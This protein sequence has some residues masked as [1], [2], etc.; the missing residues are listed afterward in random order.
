MS[1]QPAMPETRPAV[2][3]YLRSVLGGESVTRAYYDE[4]ERHA[5]AVVEAA[6][7]PSTM[8]ITFATASLHASPNNM[9]G[10]DIRVELLIVAPKDSIAAANV[11]ATAG[12]FVMKDR[13]LAAPGVVFVDAVREYFPNTTVPHLMWTEP[14]DF[15]G[16]ST[17]HVDGVDQDV[18]MLQ[19][20][21]LAES[22]RLFLIENGFDALS[23]RLEAVEA[24]HYDF[25][26]DPVC[27]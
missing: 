12:F 16:L 13:W 25:F 10:R 17:M 19:A 26:R 4:S 27:Q 2:S 18:H 21:P 6:G 20:V 5:I 1:R 11:L 3:R 8:L 9:D 24:P 22:E 7:T 15:D 23:S 14:F